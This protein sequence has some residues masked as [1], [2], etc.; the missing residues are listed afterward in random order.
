MTNQEL[1]TLVAV[2]SYCNKYAHQ[3]K[4]TDWGERRY[5]IAK[6]VAGG[7]AAN[8]E[9]LRRIIDACSEGPSPFQSYMKILASDAVEIADYVISVLKKAENDETK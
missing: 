2:E 4:T 3:S 9:F 8:D 6:S 1:R 5:E 7:L